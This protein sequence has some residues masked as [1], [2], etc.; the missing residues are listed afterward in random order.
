MG[1]S[2][3]LRID[4]DELKQQIEDLLNSNIP[5]TSKTGIH[6]LLGEILDQAEG[7]K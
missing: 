5:E 2:F 7:I 1:T 4:I 6:N 3:D